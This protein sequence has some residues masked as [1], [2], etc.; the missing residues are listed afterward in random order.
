MHLARLLITAREDRG[1]SQRDCAAR[2]GVKPQYLCA[3]ERGKKRAGVFAAAC[4]ARAL[5]E[6]VET[7]VQAAAQDMLDDAGLKF[8]V[9][10]RKR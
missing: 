1:L 3:L 5:K 2:L 6:S 7:F 10:V 9:E 8:T 4:Y